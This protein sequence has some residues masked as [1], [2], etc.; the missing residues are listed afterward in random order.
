MLMVIII[1]GCR[2]EVSVFGNVSESQ[3]LRHPV[4]GARAVMF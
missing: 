3:H 1:V 4:L 2:L